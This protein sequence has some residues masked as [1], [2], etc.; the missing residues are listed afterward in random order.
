LEATGAYSEAVAEFLH[1]R[2]HRV[3]VVNPLRIKG[4]AKS[5]L[6]RNKTD[7]ADARTIAEFC[8]AKNPENWHPLPAEIKQLQ[9]LTRRI[10]ALERMLVVETNRL[11]MASSA[12]R[13]SLKRM[14]RNLKKE[15]DNVQSLIKDHIDNHPD[16]KQQSELLQTIPGIGEKTARLLLGEIEFSQ[17]DSARALMPASLPESSSPAHRLTGPDCQNWATDV[18]EKRCTSRPSPPSDTTWLLNSLP[19]V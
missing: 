12:I 16:L 7:A 4:F 1:G 15:I 18:F 19:G 10:E 13:P 17:F 6:K 11:E 3:S 14:I 9:S 5:D 2:G 8:L